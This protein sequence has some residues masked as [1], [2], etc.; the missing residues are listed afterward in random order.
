[1][2]TSTKFL[3]A[4]LTAAALGAATLP[5]F[6]MPPG[7][8]GMGG[9]MMSQ[10]GPW[11]GTNTRFAEQAEKRQAALHKKLNLSAEQETAWKAYTEKMQA[12]SQSVSGRPEPGEMRLLSTPERLEK[13]QSMMK[14]HEKYMEGRIAAIKAFYDVLTPEQRKVFDAMAM[15][16]PGRRR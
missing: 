8:N 4:G 11:D 12:I 2:K 9:G 3:L 14:E 16:G 6:A 15:G 10:G 13:M 7:C 5:A 1:M